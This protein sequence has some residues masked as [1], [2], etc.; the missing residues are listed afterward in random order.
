[1]SA[2][3]CWASRPCA[4]CRALASLSG[5]DLADL[6][7]GRAVA[8]VRRWQGYSARDAAWL[9]WLAM[10]SCSDASMQAL[11][12]YLGGHHGC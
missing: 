12:A 5:P 4:Y 10:E 6:E 11:L 8:A 7:L 1:M 3:S 2:R 9:G